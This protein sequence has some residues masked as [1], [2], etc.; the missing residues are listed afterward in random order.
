MFFIKPPIPEKVDALTPPHIPEE[1]P[2]NDAVF[3]CAKIRLPFGKQKQSD[4]DFP[5]R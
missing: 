2:A 3:A 1:F 5:I 4:S